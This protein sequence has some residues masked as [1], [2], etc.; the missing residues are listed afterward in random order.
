VNP[1][2]TDGTEA[3][4][5][6]WVAV[7]DPKRK[8]TLTCIN[9]CSYGSDYS[10]D[11]GLRLSLIRGAAYSGHP[12]WDR[13]IVPQDQYTPRI[14]QGERIF[15]FWING[16]PTTQRLKAVDREA[17]IRNEKPFALSFFPPGQ[18]QRIKTGPIL[19]DD[20]CQISCLKPAEKGND[21]IVRVYEPTGRKRST[22]LRIPA[23]GIKKKI[24]LG[25]FEVKT[26]KINQRTRKVREVNLIEKT[27]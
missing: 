2:P 15:H 22:T 12:F 9:D 10:P 25:A 14:D 16:G 17:L 26:F 18:G 19:E 23:I 6:K 20:V 4:A 24:E 1:L 13:P 27:L 11:H 8:Q 3:V 21:L 7:V 5:Q